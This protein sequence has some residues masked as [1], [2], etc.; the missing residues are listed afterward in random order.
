MTAHRAEG[1]G[2]ALTGDEYKV[3]VTGLAFCVIW[4]EK[5]FC[6][7]ARCARLPPIRLRRTSPCSGDRIKYLEASLH[8]RLYSKRGLLCHLEEGERWWRQPPKGDCISSPAWR[9][10]G[11]PTG[12]SPIVKVLYKLAPSINVTRPPQPSAAGPLS[13][14]RTLGAIAPSNFR[15]LTPIR[16]CP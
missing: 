9:L 6:E 5:Q 8:K 13:N 3:S 7:L 4:H 16:A 10:Y 11:F 14:L 2:I 1:C 15:T 12:K